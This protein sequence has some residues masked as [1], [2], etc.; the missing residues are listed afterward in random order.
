MVDISNLNDIIVDCEKA[1]S[2]IVEIPD[3]RPTEDGTFETVGISMTM[4]SYRYG[5]IETILLA[6][7]LKDYRSMHSLTG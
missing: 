5:L 6:R 7:E 3:R 2:A 1:L 4:E